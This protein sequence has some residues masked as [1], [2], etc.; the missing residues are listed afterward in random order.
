MAPSAS[1][2]KNQIL[3]RKKTILY[4]TIPQNEQLAEELHKSIIKEF[5]KTKVYSAFKDII[6][7]AD[8]ADIQLISKFSKGFGFLLCFIDIS[9]ER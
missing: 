2:V 9:L 4:Y 7:A 1:L 5:K 3:I 8:L 6:W